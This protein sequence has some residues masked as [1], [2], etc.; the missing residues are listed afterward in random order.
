MT[1]TSTRP[2]AL[3][4]ID[5]QNDVMQAAWDSDGVVS[6]IATLIQTARDQ[7]A[8]VVYVQHED[9]GMVA[10]S[11]EWQ[12]VDAIAP[13]DDDLRVGKR[14]ADSFADTTLQETL[15]GLG[16]GHLVMCGAQTDYCVRTTTQRAL[17]EGYDV[18]LV[19]DCHTTDQEAEF[20]MTDG[21]KVPMT[22]KQIVAHQNRYFFGV[23]YPGVTAS[24]APHNEV[25]FNV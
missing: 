9:P 4:V 3:V 12:V 24:I 5:V 20:D 8:P 17:I 2:S 22:G 11:H 10:G 21:E 25:T 23:T 14:Y 7:G 1:E 15:Q 6:R 19:E 13:R 18:T 16:V